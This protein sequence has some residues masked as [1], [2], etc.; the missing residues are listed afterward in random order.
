MKEWKEKNISIIKK[1]ISAV[2][3][4]SVYLA[5]IVFVNIIL[6]N[7]PL[8]NYLGYEFSVF[9]SAV[10]ILLS[11][12]FTLSLLN[13]VPINSITEK[14]IIRSLAI[15][16]ISFL[17]LP[18]LLSLAS[19]FRAVSC[20][21]GDG[22]LF[23]IVLTL[24]APVIGIALGLLSCSLWRRFHL[25]IFLVLLIVIAAI[26]VLEIYFNPQV[27]FYNPIVGYFPGTIY[28]EGIE[29]DWKLI[30]YRFMNLVFFGTII[31][32]VFRALFT[33][34]RTSLVITWL[35]TF[36]VS[37]AFILQSPSLGYSTTYSRV[38]A[39]LSKTISTEHCEIHY[40]SAINDTLIK[41]IAL[42]HE[43]YYSELVKYFNTKPNKKVTSL[44]F[45][46]REQKKRL[47]GT[48]N[49]DV[50]KPWIPEIYLSVDNYDKTLK[51]ELAHCFAGV[52]GSRIFRIADNFNPSL[53]EGI[54]MAADPIYDGNDLDFMAALA[55][56][57][58]FKLNINNLFQSFN[59]FKQPSSLG[60][61]VA[62][63][64]IKY[65]IDTYGIER[66]K[67]LYTDLDCSR[68]YGKE[69]SVLIKEY[70]E[71]LEN[72]ILILTDVSDR[73]KYY[74]GRKSIFYKICPRYV[75]KQIN[76]AWNLFDTNRF[77]EAKEIFEELI[78]F[79]DNYSPL[80]G[81]SYCYVEMKQVQKAIDLLEENIDRYKNT[82]YYYEIEF[83]LADLVTKNNQVFEGEPIY[84]SLIKQNPNRTLFSLSKLR[85]DLIDANTIIT[86]YLNGQEH[87]KYE[88]LK[89]LNSE[90]YNYNTFPYLASLAGS[91]G[92]EYENFLKVFSKV[93][94]VGDYTSCYGIYKLSLYMC[95]KMDFNRARKM[96][97]L[98][99]RFSEDASFNSILNSNF[100]KMNWLYKN[101]TEE[102]TK[103]KY[104]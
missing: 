87:D 29:V 36:S 19:L 58:D 52:F 102:L 9:N 21:L 94:E 104:F 56:K 68:Y 10:I 96:A 24:P 78:G 37:L 95:E 22:I 77:D 31:Y 65:L 7:L 13:H 100:E 55:F 66:F 90:K 61:I 67:K 44:I 49:A 99:R 70:E 46:S 72:N 39:E 42:N 27:Y 74:Y 92:V 6:L 51:H 101:S 33:S 28:D 23:Y 83:L 73:A 11:G 2:N 18:F 64:F 5:V 54:A 62:G 75:G 15:A 48:A 26:P 89:S 71:Y 45:D 50:A 8:T 25:L 88:I 60:Y 103:M 14:Q 82:A 79:S 57:N 47:F 69:L 41:V 16:A 85:I 53:I 20:P 63:S 59:F 17:L 43:Y 80:I 30:I 91:C 76:K 35:F 34:S 4:L 86:K 38:K 32:L 93:L 1:I 98:S 12:I 40:S 84:K 81:L 3:Y 97:S